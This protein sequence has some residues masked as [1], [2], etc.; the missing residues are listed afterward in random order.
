MNTREA[1]AYLQELEGKGIK[2]GLERMQ[3]ALE[4]LE[5]S[6]GTLFVKV[7][8]TNGKGTTSSFIAKI[9]ENHGFKVGLYL[10]PH[11]KEFG[12]RIQVNA[13]KTEKKEL[14][15]EIKNLK[16]LNEKQELQLSYFEFIT[17]L[18]LKHFLKEDCNAMVLEA[19]MG[20]RL[21]ATNV[22]K[23]SLNLITN[24]S[25]EH[26]R[27]L[28]HSLERIAEEKAGIVD[29]DSVVVTGEEKEEVLKVI[30]RICRER[31]ASLIALNKN[32]SYYIKEKKLQKTKF[33]FKNKKQELKNLRINFGGIPFVKN[34]CLAIE[35]ALQLKLK[36]KAIRKGLKETK[37][38]GRMQV[39]QE[40]PLVIV[41]CAHNVAGIQELVQSVK[42]FVGK[43]VLLVFGCSDDKNFEGMVKEVS[44]IAKKVYCTQAE[45]RGLNAE[46]L[47]VEFRKNGFEEKNL[48]VEKEVK[49]AV[50]KAI[51][52]AGKQDAVLVCGSC[53]VIGET[54]T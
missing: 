5:I 2:L 4:F 41:D 29:E 14:A 34:A 26:E 50:Q 31:N 35:T 28:G 53:F 27:Y 24:V 40:K 54:L 3:K 38:I 33:N 23:A 9:L 43:P 6:E 44:R 22:V 15:K 39:L 11:V 18:A 19:G 32:F 12:E 10:S 7:A 21:D 13:R 47:E 36:R 52:K 16:N 51:R 46:M 1:F 48:E 30:R 37:L 45:Y 17:L 49:K 42:E 8:G 20:G 25:L